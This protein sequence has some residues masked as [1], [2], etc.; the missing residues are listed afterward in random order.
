MQYMFIDA[1]TLKQALKEYDLQKKASVRNTDT[2][3]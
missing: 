1:F 3:T 2:W